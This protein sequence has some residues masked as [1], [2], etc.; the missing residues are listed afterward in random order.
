MRYAV[1]RKHADHNGAATVYHAHNRTKATKTS[2][3]WECAHNEIAENTRTPPPPR[4]RKVIRALQNPSAH[5][6]YRESTLT[7]VLRN[8]LGRECRPVFVVTLSVDADDLA[9]TVASCR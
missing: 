3:R 8:S 7:S 4:R 6:P 5:I 9:E 2:V 1:R